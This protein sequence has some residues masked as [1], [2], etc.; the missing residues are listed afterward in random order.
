MWFEEGKST[1]SSHLNK[2]TVNFCAGFCVKTAFQVT[3]VHANVLV[4]FSPQWQVQEQLQGGKIGFSSQ[5]PTLGGV[6]EQCTPTPSNQ[7]VEQK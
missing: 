7:K 2:V 5:I 1:N 6:M 3:W 4:N